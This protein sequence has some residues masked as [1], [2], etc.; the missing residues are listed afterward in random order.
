[1]TPYLLAVAGFLAGL[2]TFRLKSRW[3]P[4]CGATTVALAERCPRRIPPVG[5]KPTGDGADL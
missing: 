1:M 2:F 3:C 5:R 4:M